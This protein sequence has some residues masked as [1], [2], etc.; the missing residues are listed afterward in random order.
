ME[1]EL[2]INKILNTIKVRD[3]KTYEDMN[4]NIETILKLVYK[5]YLKYTI[6]I[7]NYSIAQK[8]LLNNYEYIDTIENLRPGDCLISI[9]LS[10][11]YNMKVSNIGFFVKCVN[12]KTI[13]T[14]NFKR[15][16]NYSCDNR[17]FFRKL[18]NSDKVKIM[19]IETIGEL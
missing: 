16:F 6:N 2:E 7:N 17:L 3:I 8:K 10:R 13:R 11:F 12:D 18:N 19:L 4:K 15:F 9:D 5:D 14:I 1:F